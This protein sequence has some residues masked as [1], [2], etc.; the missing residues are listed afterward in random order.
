MKLTVDTKTFESYQKALIQEVIEQVRFKLFESGFRDEELMTLTTNIS[1]GVASTIDDQANLQFED[2]N[3]DDIHIHP[4]LTF[5]TSE[6]ELIHCGENAYSH[7]FVADI[8]KKLFKKE[9]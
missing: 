4:Y 2:D 9:N 6:D 3:Y 8:V 1:H 7:E 5:K